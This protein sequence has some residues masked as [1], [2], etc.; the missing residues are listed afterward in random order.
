MV[1]IPHLP[2]GHSIRFQ[3][4]SCR[5]CKHANVR[6]EKSKGKAPNWFDL[7]DLVLHQGRDEEAA[8]AA[9][10]RIAGWYFS[11]EAKKQKH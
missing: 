3:R 10:L 11:A 4:L 2:R 9:R 5:H 1:A 6:D 8:E 7:G